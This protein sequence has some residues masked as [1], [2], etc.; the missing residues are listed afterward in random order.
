M[1][2]ASISMLET[3]LVTRFLFFFN[4]YMMIKR[5][6]GSLITKFNLFS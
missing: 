1:T 6:I 5:T 4:N 2:D 3:P